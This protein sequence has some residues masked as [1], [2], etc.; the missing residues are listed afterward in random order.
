MTYTEDAR[1]PRLHGDGG[2]LTGFTLIEISIV[3]AI[4]GLLIGGIVLARDLIKTAEIRSVIADVAR[5]Q[6][7]IVNF[8][9]KYNYLPGD[10]PDAESFWD[11]DAGGCPN[12]VPS[13]AKAETC[14]GD[15]IGTIGN[16][17][18]AGVASN[19]TEW[20]RAWQHLANA[21]F[22]EG[23]YSGIRGIAGNAESF[24]F[25]TNAP[26]S[27]I[28]GCGWV[29]QYIINTAGDANNF[30]HM[31]KHRLLLTQGG[32]DVSWPPCIVP[33]DAL[34]FDTKIDDGLPASGKVID[35]K[36]NV[37]GLHHRY[38]ATTNVASTALYNITYDGP[39]CG[40]TIALGF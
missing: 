2:L 37:A 36:G 32:A 14:D 34:D 40:P 4:I 15:G 5:F 30:A 9:E 35:K 19:Q 3:I 7:A 1:G 22:I 31:Q 25:G 39:A 33:D 20:H 11:T 10:F 8:R 17:T 21:G 16:S 28:M 24:V 26:P 12:N 27:K 38:C 6:K 18:T 23:Q 13:A 29:L